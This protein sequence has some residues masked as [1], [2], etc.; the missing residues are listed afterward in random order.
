[1][2]NLAVLAA[3]VLALNA[4]ASRSGTSGGGSDP[5]ALAGARWRLDA[6]SMSALVDSV[7]AGADV[8]IEFAD[9]QASGSSGCNHYGGSY[10]AKDDGSISYGHFAV[11]LM[12]CPDPQMALEAAYLKALSDSTTFSVGDT[13]TLSGGPHSLTFA[14]ET[15]QAPPPLVGTTWTLGAFASGATVSASSTEPTLVLAADGSA[16]GSAGCNTYHGTYTTGSNTLAFGPLA[17]TMKHCGDQVMSEEHAFL[18]AM[19]KV[20]GYA[21]EG[22]QLT[23]TDAGGATLL[24]FE[25]PAA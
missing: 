24:T 1:M 16:S 10:D 22:T 18:E 23:L 12:A 8:T 9:G 25:A 6:A 7:P 2:R 19:G 20:K 11:T 4:C 17:T 15:P 5:S 21:I 3:V 13:L 14:K